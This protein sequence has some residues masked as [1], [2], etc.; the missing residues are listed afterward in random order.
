MPKYDFSREGS[1]LP[2]SLDSSVS[3]SSPPASES[4]IDPSASTFSR[5]PARCRWSF[6]FCFRAGGELDL[7]SGGENRPSPARAKLDSEKEA[8]WVTGEGDSDGGVGSWRFGET[9]LTDEM[10]AVMV[11]VVGGLCWDWL[12]G[13]AGTVIWREAGVCRW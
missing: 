11:M 1:T 9:L 3:V 8:K 7:D 2:P 5:L 10:G 4:V 13:M 12:A 6:P